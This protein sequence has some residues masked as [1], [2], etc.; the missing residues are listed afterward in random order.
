[1][2]SIRENLTFPQALFGSLYWSSLFQ[3]STTRLQGAGPLRKDIHF[4]QQVQ[5]CWSALIEIKTLGPRATR[6]WHEKKRADVK[7]L[8]INGAW[9]CVCF[10][11]QWLAGGM[12][13]FTVR[14]GKMGRMEKGL[15]WHA[16]PHL[17][18]RALTK[19]TTCWCLSAGNDLSHHRWSL[20]HT[21][22]KF[23]VCW[24]TVH[25]SF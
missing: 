17:H 25:K 2:N 14:R 4:F 5:N 13:S 10:R 1:M 19:T 20:I 11:H 23:D 8:S 21:L 12:T 15:L 18:P 22:F 7:S 6:L 3:N 16:V 24:G 9:H